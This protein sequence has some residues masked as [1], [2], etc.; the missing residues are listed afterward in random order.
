ML[1][2]NKNS[3]S[4]K[5][6]KFNDIRYSIS[7]QILIHHY[8]ILF[9]DMCWLE[10]TYKTLDKVI[11][12][13]ID[14]L[15]VRW[16]ETF[17]KQ[18]EEE[19]KDEDY[20]H[21][22]N[23]YEYILFEIFRCDY[24]SNALRLQPQ[25]CLNLDYDKFEDMYEWLD[26]SWFKDYLEGTWVY[27]N[28]EDFNIKKF[29]L[30]NGSIG[31]IGKLLQAKCKEKKID[32][33]F[34]KSVINEFL[35]KWNIEKLDKNKKILYE[36]YEDF[37]SLFAKELLMIVSFD[38]ETIDVIY[39]TQP[40]LNFYIF[41]D[42]DRIALERNLFKFDFNIIITEFKKQIMKLPDSMTENEIQNYINLIQKNLEV[43]LSKYKDVLLNTIFPEQK[44]FSLCISYD[45]REK[46]DFT[47]I[48]MDIQTKYIT[49]SLFFDISSFKKI[50]E[51]E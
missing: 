7:W 32:V 6:P 22:T 33:I 12:W 23:I 19:M 44:C 13:Y 1:R 5:L 45:E 36:I 31:F 17:K 26:S 4:N 47:K 16:G 9:A 11:N 49:Y 10:Y 29:P 30:T 35:A 42:Y 25:S 3:E 8:K 2:W 15:I 14:R 38:Y 34:C 18:I 46:I 27:L 20:G 39:D 21:Y 43:P 50:S 24:A 51:K 48:Y 28:K 40:Y 37:C 41:D